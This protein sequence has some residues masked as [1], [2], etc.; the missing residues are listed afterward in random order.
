MV[1]EMH[2]RLSEIAKRFEHAQ[3]A[4]AANS[5]QLAEL[6]GPDHPYC[7]CYI[8]LGNKARYAFEII[9]CYA[10][11]FPAGEELSQDQ[12][13]RIIETE[14]WY[15]IGVLSVVEYSMPELIGERGSESL[16]HMAHNGPFAQFL[17]KALA[18]KVIEENEKALFDFL[19]R[20]RNDLIHRNGVSCRSETINYQGRT[21]SL[22]KNEM[23]EG[24]WGMLADLG[25]LAT[26]LVSSVIK[27]IEANLQGFPE[28]EG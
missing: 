6:F 8:R 24:Y 20:V 2:A 10:H 12:M 21:F 27:H 28:Y 14:K 7:I 3:R 15:F 26:H 17:T 18:E 22:R 23:I 5:A 16:R 25:A 9:E 19:S 11:R 4:C 1:D 13:E